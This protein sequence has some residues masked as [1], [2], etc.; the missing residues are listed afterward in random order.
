MAQEESDKVADVNVETNDDG[1]K[2]ATVTTEQGN[3]GTGS[4]SGGILSEPSTQE[5]TA[6][7]VQDA[8]S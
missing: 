3:T 2:S 8:K 4:S 7:A 5:A 6:E 1:S